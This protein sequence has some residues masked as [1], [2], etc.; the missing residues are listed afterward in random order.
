MKT[1]MRDF[2]GQYL[3]VFSLK[4]GTCTHRPCM[5]KKSVV[6]NEF[7]NSCILDCKSESFAHLSS[8]QK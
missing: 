3:S 8:Y 6:L 1:G 4:N 5:N 7:L 2:T